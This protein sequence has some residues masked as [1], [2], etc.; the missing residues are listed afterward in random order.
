MLI[1]KQRVERLVCGVIVAWGLFHGAQSLQ[2]KGQKP[3][4]HEKPS[5]IADKLASNL[6]L[7]MTAMTAPGGLQANGSDVVLIDVEAVDAD[8]NRCPT[9]YGR[10]DFECAGPGV[11]RGG[12]N[13]GKTNSINNLFLDLECGINRVAVRSTLKSGTLSLGA[14]SAG[15]KDAVIKIESQP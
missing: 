10:V 8:G 11:W 14:R 3:P 13:S 1:G 12:Y 6:E 5:K 4:E 2:A 9:F 7:R 15:L